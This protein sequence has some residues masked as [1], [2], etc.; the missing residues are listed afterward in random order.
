M[1]K[2]V[3]FLERLPPE[4]LKLIINQ[5]PFF[6]RQHSDYWS[7]EKAMYSDYD[8]FICTGGKA[9]FFQGDEI[10]LVTE[11]KA[12]LAV[13]GAPLFAKNI[14]DDFFIAAAQH[15]D[16]KV[17][18]EIDFFSLINYRKLVKFSDWG[19][20]KSLFDKYKKLASSGRKRLEQYS[21]FHSILSEF[22]YD[23]FLSENSNQQ[24][25]YNFI[26]QMLSS[27]QEHLTEED[28]LRKALVLSPYSHDYTSRVFKKR[29]GIP[30]KQY[31]LKS[32]LDLSRTLLLQEGL[33]IK[34]I[35]YRCGFSD[36]LYFSRLFR[37][38][39][40]MSP[41]EFRKQHVSIGS[42]Y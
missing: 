16:L 37:K 39:L 31:I 22:I 35:A 38:Y 4:S 11:G 2:T 21:L 14:G 34:E 7:I 32:R 15:F 13:P 25:E 33:S 41:G 3:D 28:V 18:G 26:F 42:G 40:D 24:G 5:Q 23:A 8:L 6:Q 9:E 20:V 27:I 29:I 12:F 17:F 10:Y 30:P 19:Y 36:E 1:D